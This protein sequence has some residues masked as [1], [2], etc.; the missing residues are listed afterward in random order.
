M[1][2]TVYCAQIIAIYL[3]GA[4]AFEQ[5][6]NQPL[7]VMTLVTM[8]C[9]TAWRVF[10]GRGPLEQLRGVVAARASAIGPSAPALR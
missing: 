7:L 8:V 1:A 9:A 3:W 5:T 2:L 4:A 10:L 6:S